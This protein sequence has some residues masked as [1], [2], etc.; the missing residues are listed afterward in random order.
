MTDVEHWAAAERLLAAG[1]AGEARLAFEKLRDSDQL[2]IAARMR[3]SLIEDR[4]GNL[5]GAVDEAASAAEL[6]RETDPDALSMLFKR[7]ITLGEQQLALQVASRPPLAR[8][9]NIQTLA[10]VGKL[11][12]DYGFPAE[13]RLMLTR[14]NQL[15]LSS[16]PV[17]YLLGTCAMRLG[18]TAE[19]EQQFERAISINPAFAPSHWHLAKL[20][21]V[22]AEHNHVDRLRKLLAGATRPPEAA[23][24]GYALFKELD[25]LGEYDD[26]WRVWE[27][28]AGQMKRGTGYDVRRD[29]ALMDSLREADLACAPLPAVIDPDQTGLA[30]I[31]IVGLPRSGTTLLERAFGLHS[32]VS[33]CGELVDMVN[34]LRYTQNVSGAA[35][36]D[37][38]MARRLP[39]TDFS[40]LGERYIGHVAWRSAGKSRITDKMPANF[41]LVGAILRS[42]PQARIVHMFRD[43]VA[44]CFSNLR[45]CFFGGNYGYSNN[46]ADMADYHRS[47]RALMQHW[48]DRYPSRVH[49][50]RYEDLVSDTEGQLRQ[51]FAHCGLEWQ[52]A[53][54]HTERNSS[55]V[56]TASATQVREPINSRSV[57]H[58]RRYEQHLLPMIDALNA[59]A[60]G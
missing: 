30:P 2:G 46:L 28:A 23:M 7:L 5:R 34:Q 31:F 16:A 48:D 54:V 37:V 26:A 35:T 4:D 56:T 25:D 27:G 12:C 40:Q 39:T 45:E 59:A 19:A 53:C 33:A 22:T 3:L 44:G 15:G 18:E 58:W 32:D 50:V 36:L 29:I 47:Y 20:S 49:P 8:S 9:Q 38:A 55:M 11:L 51:A 42:M 24:L 60:A 52:P 13:S 57:E 21:R 17:H 1:R 43:P 10:E 14:A 6:D 41:R